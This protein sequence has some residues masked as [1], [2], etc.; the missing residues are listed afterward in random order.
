MRDLDRIKLDTDLAV[1]DSSTQ[2]LI[3]NRTVL[4]VVGNPNDEQ[5]LNVST[6]YPD[7]V[8]PTPNAFMFDPE[9]QLSDTIL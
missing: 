3:A 9:H 6:F 2:L 8:S 5:D 7:L 1:D 4:D